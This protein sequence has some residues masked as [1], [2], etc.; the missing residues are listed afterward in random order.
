MVPPYCVKG[1]IAGRVCS[2][3]Y[4]ERHALPHLHVSIDPKVVYLPVGYQIRAGRQVAILEFF[5]YTVTG[6]SRVIAP[7]P[8]LTLL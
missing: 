4:V 1:E 5:R 2:N 3:F 8:S 6:P 7:M